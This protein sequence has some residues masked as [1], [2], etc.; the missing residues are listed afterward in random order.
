MLRRLNVLYELPYVEEVLSNV[1]LTT[2]GLVHN[3]FG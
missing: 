1:Q 3:L 2:E